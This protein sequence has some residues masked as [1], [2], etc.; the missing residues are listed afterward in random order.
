M[1]YVQFKTQLDEGFKALRAEGWYAYQYAKPLPDSHTKKYVFYDSVDRNRMVRAFGNAPG[2]KGGPRG[3]YLTWNGNAQE[4]MEVFRRRGLYVE[5]DGHS[6][7][8]IW[9]GTNS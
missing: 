6:A 9:V 2:T 3:V 4:I 7:H 1:N 8:R 5:W